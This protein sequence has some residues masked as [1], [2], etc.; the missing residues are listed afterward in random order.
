[1][2]LNKQLLIS[3][4]IGVSI[5]T[6]GCSDKEE[7]QIKELEQQIIKLEQQINESKENEQTKEEKKTEE[8]KESDFTC[9]IC[10]GVNT[11]PQNSECLFPPIDPNYICDMCGGKGTCTASDCNHPDRAHYLCEYCSGK[12]NYEPIT[13]WEDSVGNMHVTHSGACREYTE[14]LYNDYMNQFNTEGTCAK[15]LCDGLL[16]P[17]GY[18]KSCFSHN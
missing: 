2:K 9:P 16:N 17:E 6:A 1:M 3:S 14:S 15:C 18:C 8:K 12:V 13:Y 11:C 4:I 10:G 7:K 5:L